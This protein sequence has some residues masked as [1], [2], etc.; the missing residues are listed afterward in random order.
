MASSVPLDTYQTF[1]TNN[2]FGSKRGSY[3][4]LMARGTGTNDMYVIEVDPVTGSIPVAATLNVS[5][6]G[7]AT[8]AKQDTGNTSLANIDAGIPAAL[9]QTTMASSMPVT[10]ASDQ[11][12]LSTTSTNFPTTVDTNTGAAGASTIRVV[13]STRSEASATPLAV[14][15]GN[16]TNFDSY[17]TGADGATVPR[18][19]LSTRAETVST[20][21]AAQLSNGTN[22]ITYGTGAD[23]TSTI[24]ATLST[25]AEAV[26]TPLAAQLSNGSAAIAYGTG[27]DGATVIRTT[28][29]TRHEAAATPLSVRLSDG[30]SFQPTALKSTSLKYR[31]D[32]SSV[33][34]TTSAYVQI[35][36]STGAVINK[37]WVFDS[38]GSAIIIATGAAASEV[39]Q[40]Y[41]PP[42]G[43]DTPFEINIA[44]STRLSMKALDTSATTGQIIL[45]CT[46]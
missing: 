22:A 2:P 38:S 18:V 39:D 41:I 30:S 5:T 17:G 25:R 10:L 26:A 43:F 42:G 34:V 36:A 37:C 16:G 9:G 8:S 7:L 3:S 11:T 27:A 20:P 23:S 24:R 13:P 40:F 19:T 12:A 45:N 46:N 35:I 32:Y 33:N 4:S 21:L 29:S 14:R 1:I 31:N 44:A 6:S 28:E 15:T